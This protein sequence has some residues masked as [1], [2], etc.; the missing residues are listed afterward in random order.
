MKLFVGFLFLFAVAMEACANWLPREIHEVRAYVYDCSQEENNV[1]LLS[2]GRLH[3]GVIN[4]SGAR[5]S[6]EQVERLKNALRSSEKRGPSA[7]C[8]FPHH[9]FIFFDKEGNAM[10]HIE[11]CFKCGNVRSSPEGLPDVQWNW[12]EIREILGELKIPILESM[13]GYTKLYTES[14]Q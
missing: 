2:Q 11:L 12:K 10:G 1:T 13:E 5:L 9:G 6:V 7:L 4:E 8:Y 3:K 14:R